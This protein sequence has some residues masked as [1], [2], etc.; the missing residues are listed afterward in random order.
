MMEEVVKELQA[1]IDLP[2]QIDTS[3]PGPWNGPFRSTTARR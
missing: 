1:I 2:L 3:I